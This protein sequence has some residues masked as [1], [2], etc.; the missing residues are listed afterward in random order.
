S[1]KS[2]FSATNVLVGP[3]LFLEICGVVLEYYGKISKSSW[4]A[5]CLYTKITSDNPLHPS[6]NAKCIRN[7]K[8][9]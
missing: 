9:Y 5:F 4:A 6:A 7:N 3:F 2:F 8:V 1:W